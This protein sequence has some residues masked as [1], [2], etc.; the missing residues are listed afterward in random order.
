MTSDHRI[1]FNKR[2]AAKNNV[3]QKEK[4]ISLSIG[5]TIPLIKTDCAL[6]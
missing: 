1:E 3:K 2:N 6:A 5:E 4:N